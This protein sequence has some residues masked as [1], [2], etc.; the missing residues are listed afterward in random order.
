MHLVLNS[1]DCFRAR[2][3]ESIPQFKAY[4]NQSKDNVNV[5]LY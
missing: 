2:S 3:Y 4:I 1:T 5:K